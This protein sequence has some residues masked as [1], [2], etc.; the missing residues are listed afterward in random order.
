MQH[1]YDGQLRK[2][3]TQ[4]IRFFSN[5]VVK[6]GD[7]SLQ[8]IPV[9]Y[10]DPDKQVSSIMRQNSENAINSA[11][12]ISVYVTGLELDRDRMCDSTFVGKLHFRSRDTYDGA[13]SSSQG[14]TYTVERLMP[15]PFKLTMK[16]DIWAA[17]TD[18]KLQILEQILIFFNPSVELQSSDN[19]IDWTSL[20]VLNLE[21]ISWSSRTVPVGNTL[22][23]DV[24]TLTVDSP[25]WL[26]PPVKVKQLGVITSIISNINNSYSKS[27]VGYIE[28]LGI[29]TADTT[30]S[31][32]QVLAREHITIDDY[33]IE[34]Y[35]NKASLMYSSI[36][37][38]PSSWVELIDKYPGKYISN[39][40]MIFLKQADGSEVSGTFSVDEFSPNVLNITWNPDTVMSNTGIDSSGKLDSYPGYNSAISNRPNSPGT[41]D[42]IIDPLKYNPKR[43]NNEPTNQD[44]DIGTR[45]LIID[46][47]GNISNIDGADGWK[48]TDNSELVAYTNDIVEW[49]GVKWNVIFNS[50]SMKDAMIWQTNIFTGTQYTWNGLSWVKSFDREYREGEW[51]IVL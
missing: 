50:L 23:I 51:R 48:G 7:G 19:Y 26:S 12:R 11:P 49:D 21:N 20:S 47:I 24:A 1:Y 16:V 46:D 10:G 42:A 37:A 22:S 33:N 5:F 9:A 28:G 41:F 44:I 45:F 27:P 3:I 32:S 4:T 8:R 35:N 14:K 38:A 34:V 2:F 31:L 40:S 36:E 43:P 39:L 29:D 17:N 18:Q 6:N 13:Y 30:I 25:I 15:T